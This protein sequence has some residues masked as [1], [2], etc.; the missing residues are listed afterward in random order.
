MLGDPFFRSLECKACFYR[1]DSF[2][3]RRILRG[4][5]EHR[6]YAIGEKAIIKAINPKP[7]QSS[8]IDLP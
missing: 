4:A 1:W 8:F 6:G 7:K 3:L 5:L 2:H